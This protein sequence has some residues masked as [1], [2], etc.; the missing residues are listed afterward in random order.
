[1]LVGG[2]VSKVRMPIREGA[3]SMLTKSVGG[4]LQEGGI[5][6]PSKP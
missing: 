3:Y 2:M 6:S 5:E 4:L 1:M